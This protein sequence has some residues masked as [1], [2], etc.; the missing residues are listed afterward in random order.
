MNIDT[1]FPQAPTPLTLSRPAERPAGGATQRPVDR[2]QRADGVT[3]RP[4]RAGG[5]RTG[6]REPAADRGIRADERELSEQERSEVEKLKQ[7]DREVRA[8]EA[9]HKAAAGSLAR[10]GAN[11]EYQQGPDGRRYAVGGEV[12]I[13]TSKVPDDPQATLRKAQ[14]IRRAANAPAQPS[15]Q[16]RAVA[17]EA[18]RMEAEARRELQEERLSSDKEQ[19]GQANNGAGGAPALSSRIQQGLAGSAP[20]GERLDVMA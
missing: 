2:P 13:D 10:G 9:A 7:R 5:G 17:T 14:T 4:Q 15:G 12:S 19:T 3:D 16:D 6:T 11:F 18:G 8:H 1:Q 20:V